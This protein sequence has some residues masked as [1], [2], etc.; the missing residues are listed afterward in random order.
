MIVKLS[1]DLVIL[2]FFTI[3]IAYSFIIGKNQTLKV[4]ISTYIAILTADGLA[5][6]LNEYILEKTPVLRAFNLQAGDEVLIFIKI[7]V[8]IAAVVLIS[9]KGEFD[10]SLAEERNQGLRALNTFIVGFFNAGLI[11]S[12]VMIYITGLSFIQPETGASNAAI[13]SFYNQSNIAQ[14]LISNYNLWFFIPALA[15]VFYSFIQEK[16][17]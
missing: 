5:N 16:A 1:W 11:I 6:L 14:A 4:I 8:L 2:I 12:T 7:V 3:I 17:E 10:I 9:V 15:F 13:L